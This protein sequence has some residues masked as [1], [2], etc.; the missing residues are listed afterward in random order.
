MEINSGSG[1]RTATCPICHGEVEI[2]ARA[3]NAEGN[4]SIQ[5]K[6]CKIPVSG[7]VHSDQGNGPATTQEGSST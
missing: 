4:Y 3:V 2:P 7:K 1:I 6:K 5:C